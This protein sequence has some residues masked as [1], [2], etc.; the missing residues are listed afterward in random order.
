ML[1]TL[2]K[3]P[4]RN[5]PALSIDDLLALYRSMVRIRTFENRAIELF[6]E[7]AVKGSAHSYVG[8]EAIAAGVALSLGADDFVTSYHR[9]HGHC[10]VKGADMRR[11]MAE[12]L[13]RADGYCGGLGGSMHIADLS[14]NILG[15]NGI[16]GAGIGLALG[17][18]LSTK[19]DGTDRVGIAF[20]GDGASNEGLF[21]EALNMAAIW[22][23]PVV[24]VCENNKYGMSTS[25][26][27]ST[28]VKSIAV[29]ARGYDIPGVSV[30]GNDVSAVAGA[31]E[32]AVARAR[33][34]DGPSLIEN[35]TYRWRGHSKSDRNRYRTRE[36]IADW[37]E[38]DPI[39]RF[40]A[41]LIQHG[42]MTAAEVDA[43]DA[44]TARTIAEAIEYARNG[45][46]PKVSDLARDVYT[47]VP[48]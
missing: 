6:K 45:P 18:A 14:L 17:A 21:H 42:I 19:L 25:I 3:R 23:L 44:E 47:E 22:K 41:D 37:M 20:F 34:G 1:T 32:A 30:D 15:S 7:G 4:V 2:E 5:V 36:E 48:A 11:M 26:H 40:A 39:P 43:L 33:A 27:R 9:G 12:L 10:L 8:E 46:D 38:K 24:F 31:V 16:V 35:V 28:S 29:R 13:G